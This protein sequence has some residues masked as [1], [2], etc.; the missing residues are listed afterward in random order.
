MRGVLALVVVAAHAWQIFIWPA[1]G[2]PGL[3]AL[4]LLPSARVAVLAFFALSGYVIAASLASN[5]RVPRM[6]NIE[7]Y[8]LA[9]VFRVVPPLLVIIGLTA[10]I[11]AV[12][13]RAGADHDF[14]AG[15][16]R[17]VY[18]TDPWGQLRALATLCTQ[19]ELTGAWLNGPLW[20]LAYEIRMY[21]VAGLLA[22][23]LC[24]RGWL[25]RVVALLLAWKFVAAIKLGASID[26]LDLQGTAFAAF[27]SGSIA[28]RLRHM[29]GRT[30]LSVATGFALVAAWRAS[31]SRV[32]LVAGL[33][34]DPVLLSAQV[35]LSACGA[36][37]IPLVARMPAW[38]SL[39][40]MGDHSYTL[41]IGHFPVLLAIRFV[42]A[43]AW[44]SALSAPWTLAGL[45]GAAA[46]FGLSRLGRW[47]ERPSLQL[48]F[49]GRSVAACRSL[50]TYL[51]ASIKVG[52][53][54]GM[55]YR[56]GEAA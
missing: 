27:A 54:R 34:S 46:W 37:L 49:A 47:I 43:N 53:T 5:G 28:Y 14:A 11:A 29:R 52:R 50:G 51:A 3:A 44:P 10:A 4:V 21:V 36:L 42:L 18:R 32:A 33:D 31:Q 20:S 2:A 1:E 12:L 26:G 40:R 39:R 56:T 45:A 7:R 9:R 16:A 55:P 17:D 23:V 35:A 30:L 38:P 15:V 48:A 41:Y 13:A 6:P 22:C 24:A 19:G 25:A 8:V